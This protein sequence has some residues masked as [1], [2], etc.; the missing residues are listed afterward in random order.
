MEVLQILKTCRSVRSFRPHPI[1]DDVLRTVLDHLRLAPS[2]SNLQPWHFLV[3]RDASM[4]RQLASAAR[5]QLFLA[6]APVLVVACGYPERAQD[7][8]GGLGNSLRVDIAV[9]FDRMMLAATAH[10]LGTCW[11]GAYDEREVREILGIPDTAEVIAITPLGYPS[12]PAALREGG[13]DDRLPFE[14]VIS[15]DRY[16]EVNQP[17]T[18]PSTAP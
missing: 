2:A 16:P 7:F 15:F 6:E 5:N 3:V 1:E 13:P 8:L 18:P 17:T 10:G 14:S 4:R 11:I 9:A 12:D